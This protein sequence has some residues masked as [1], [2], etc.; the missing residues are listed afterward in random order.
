MEHRTLVDTVAEKL[1]EEIVAGR[2]APGD[3][4]PAESDIAVEY[5]VSRLTVREALTMLRTINVI[6]VQRGRG[7][8]ITPSDEW[9][10]VEAI[11]RAAAHST[12]NSVAS[13][14]LLEVRRLVESGAAALAAA[15][16]SDKDVELLRRELDS[17]AAADAAGDAD[18]FVEADRLFH[19]LILKM[20]GNTLFAAVFVPM[21]RVLAAARREAFTAPPVRART[22]AMHRQ[23]LA[24]VERGDQQGARQ[25]M[26]DHVDQIQ[27]DLDGD[28]AGLSATSAEG[29]PA[30]AAQQAAVV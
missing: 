13:R 14:Q 19:T 27:D 9:T 11:V 12:G 26:E 18:V 8:F 25:A 17:M 29:Q 6:S 20:S 28:A 24:A 22:L 15:R 30:A 3:A 23:V 2:L 16:R 1:L 21:G 7:T 10:S 4:L 5:Q